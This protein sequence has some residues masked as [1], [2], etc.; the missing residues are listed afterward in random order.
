[1]NNYAKDL[2]KILSENKFMTLPG[3]YD[4]LSARIAQEAGFSAFPLCR[5]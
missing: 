4:C 3:V 5:A 2:R 1:M